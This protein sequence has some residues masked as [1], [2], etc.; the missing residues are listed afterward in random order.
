LLGA[1]CQAKVYE[2]HYQEDNVVNSF[3]IKV[4]NEKL[5]LLKDV[6]E[7]EYKILQKLDGH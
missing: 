7:R 6:F 1:G 4:F 5:F 3:A 2:A